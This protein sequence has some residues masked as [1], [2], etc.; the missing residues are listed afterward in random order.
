MKCVWI[1]IGSKSILHQYD[2]NS[3]VPF[4]FIKE[5]KIGNLFELSS[6]RKYDISWWRLRRS[7]KM[8]RN[9]AQLNAMVF[10]TTYSFNQP[11]F[12][13]SSQC[14][15]KKIHLYL[16]SEKSQRY[17]QR[18]QNFPWSG[19]GT[20]SLGMLV[21]EPGRGRMCSVGYTQKSEIHSGTMSYLNSIC[22]TSSSR[23]P[24]LF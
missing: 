23:R 12:A 4:S 7:E 17:L 1:W 11:P 8:S 21:A 18:A 19:D 10:Q 2:E 22:F 9:L 20:G 15:S 3:K 16:N 6:T 24:K 5:T 14:S 13:N